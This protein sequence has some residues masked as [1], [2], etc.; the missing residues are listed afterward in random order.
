MK[1][2]PIGQYSKIYGKT[3]SN[4]VMENFLEAGYSDVGASEI[5]SLTGISKPKVYQT[6]EEFMKKGYIIKSRVVGR[7]QLYKLNKENMIVR[8]FLRNFN[9]CLQIVANEYSKKKDSTNVN[10]AVSAK[11]L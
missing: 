3:I 9:E 7:T 5:V 2:L 1:H 10:I 4:R 11:T 8:I 6:I